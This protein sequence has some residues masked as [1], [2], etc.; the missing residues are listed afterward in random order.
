MSTVEQ[1]LPSLPNLRDLGGL[2][3]RDGHR[4]RSGVLYRSEA[5]SLAS[6]TDVDA[7]H[8]RL[9]IAEVIDLRRADEHETSPLP[10]ALAG[11]V[12]WHRVPF[13]IDA[14]VHLSTPAPGARGMTSAEMGQFYAWLVQRNVPQL[15]QVLALL[16]DVDA[17]ALIHCAIGKDRTGV[18]VALALLAVGVERSTVLADYARSDTAMRTVLPRHDARVTDEILEA[19]M[20]MRAPE[21]SM[22]ACLDAIAYAQGSLAAFL[23]ELD[24]DGSIR[25]RLRGRL[26]EP[27]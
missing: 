18:T 15:R 19:D 5:P 21:A 20:R 11:R 13:D 17:P 2:P 22:S 12:R 6:T 7:L 16:S 3:T 1:L 8:A 24:A 14:P 4:T 25:R 27:A 23:D 10:S 26:L 9:R